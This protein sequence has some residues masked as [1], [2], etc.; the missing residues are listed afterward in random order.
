MKNSRIVIVSFL[1]IIIISSL[2]YAGWRYAGQCAEKNADT[3][4]ICGQAYPLTVSEIN[5]SGKDLSEE[6]FEEKW[7]K[8]TCLQTADLTGT[9][10]TPPQF[11][12]LHAANPSCAIT[13]DVPLGAKSCRSDTVSLTLDPAIAPSDISL[14]R[15][16]SALKTLDARQYPLCDELFE[17]TEELR[18][19]A[20]GCRCLF[21]GTLYGSPIDGDSRNFDFSSA[22]ITDLSAFYQVLRFFPDVESI[23]L[24]DIDVPDKDVSE[25][26]KAFP[27]TKI[28]WLVEFAYWQVRTDIKVFS[29]LIGV[30][31]KKPLDDEA[32]YPLLAYCTDLRA[33]DLG[34]N[35]LSDISLI[36][37]L[38]NLEVLILSGNRMSSIEAVGSLKKLNYLEM[39]NCENVEDLSPIANCVELEDLMLNNM[40]TVR[41]A[42]SLANCKKLRL[43]YARNTAPQ[44]YTWE[45]LQ[46]ALPDCKIDTSTYHIRGEWRNSDKNDA[47]RIAFNHWSWI[48]AYN[49]W[50][51]YETEDTK[52][53]WTNPKRHQ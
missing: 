46:Q 16:C 12:A 10:L 8:L 3:V 47:I 14:I 19:P 2:I 25:L 51:D 22:A 4:T 29:T 53:G 41:H 28:V 7:L 49:S 5:L 1:S 26:N 27:E 9:G 11:D 13:W 17:A 30:G 48:S 42:D 31:N 43:L 20:S 21:S 34:H 52:V 40:G 32:V 18:S 6:Q 39:F 37:G 15:Y 36:A 23:Y 33:L 44:G 38:E 35:L 45:E 24:G 50:D